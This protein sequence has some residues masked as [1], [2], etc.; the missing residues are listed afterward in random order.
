MAAT[1][2]KTAQRL[3]SLDVL[4]GFTVMAMVLVNTP[5]SW[6]T[7]YAPLRHAAWHGVTPTDLIFPFFLFIVG[8]S[9]ALAFSKARAQG[10]D[11]S[12]LYRKIIART[13]KLLGLG[14]GLSLLSM[15]TFHQEYLRI[16]GVLQRIGVAFGIASTLYLWWGEKWLRGIGILLLLGYWALLALVPT[17]GIGEPSLAP[18]T[19]LAAWLDQLIL[20][21][22]VWAFTKPYD[23]E[24]ILSTL[25]AIAT[26]FLG[27]SI[28]ELLKN[29][30]ISNPKKAYQLLLIGVALVLAG[31]GWGLIFPLNKQLWTS[32]YV[33]FSGGWATLSLGACLYLIDVR[34]YQSTLTKGCIVFGSNAITVYVLA[35]VLV[36]IMHLI[37]IGGGSLH[38]Q[39]YQYG[40]LSWLS[41]YNASLLFAVTYTFL[42]FL[43]AWWMYQNKIFLKV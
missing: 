41:P 17:P 42:C 13:L 34:Q 4:R 21:N 35:A 39:I 26:V 8:V 20:G 40:F 6:D 7:V 29:A 3:Q 25:P 2:Q 23:P 32:S 31:W 15:L 30:E 36:Y 12:G 27:I 43:P 33:L 18:T 10:A 37:P 38:D 16:P 22:H 19:N 24:G 9:I 5:G 1:Q 14:L 11:K 28:G